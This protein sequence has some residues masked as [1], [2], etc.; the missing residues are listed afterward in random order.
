MVR[1]RQR[2]S[3]ALPVLLL[4]AS[5]LIF[6]GRVI[7]S[8]KPLFGSDFVLYFHP[9]KKFIHDYALTHGT[10]AFW[11]PHQFSG[12]PVI[13]NIQASM[14]YPLG[15]LFYLM[16]T[17]YA[18][19]YTI[20]VHCI[21]GTIFMYVLAR[22]FS[23]TK[24]GAFLAGIV[25][26][27][28]GFFMGHLYAGHLTFVQNYI[29]IP[30]IFFYV[31][32]FLN[33]HHLGYAMMAGLI[34]GIQILG[35]FPQIAFYTILAIILLG[36][37]RISIKLRHKERDAIFR[38]S[39]GMFIIPLLGFSLAAVQLLPTYEFTQ[40]SARSGGV[41]YEFATS[42]SFDPVNFITFLMPNFFG[43]PANG[44]YW[45][46]TQLWQFAELCG[47]VGIAPLLL[48]CF[49]KQGSKARHVRFFFGMLLVLS[50]FLS[51]GRY[52]P[53]YRFIYHLPGFHHFRIPAQ[54][55]YLCVFSVSILAAMGLN[56][57]GRFESYS[58]SYKILLGLGSLVFAVLITAL[59]LL[60]SDLF[61]Y[62]LRVIRP[63]GLTPDLMSQLHKTVRV[64][65]FTGAGVFFLLT[66]L[67]HLRRKH[68]LAASTFITMLVVIATIDLWCFSHSLIRTTELSPHRGKMQLTS[69][70][71]RDPEIHRVVV[72]SDRFWPNDG[73]LY[74]YEDIQGY[75]P[76]ILKRYLAYLNRSQNMPVR[77]EAVNIEFVTQLDNQLIEMLNVK[78]AISS[79]TRILK[80]RNHMPRAFFVR[81]AVT[82]PSEEV[83]DFMMSDDFDPEEVVVLEDNHK[84][85]DLADLFSGTQGHA[86]KDKAEHSTREDSSESCQ[87]T[88][89]GSD[90]IN[91][92]VDVNEDGYLVLSEISYPGWTAYVNGK[93]TE[94][95][96]G[97]YIFRVLPL[98]K[99]RH[100]VVMRFE[101]TSFK[102]GLMITASALVFFV[103]GLSSLYIRNKTKW[104]V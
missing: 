89:Y 79:D 56:G 40:L 16:P 81:K 96:T 104:P 4:V 2:L 72:M 21:L 94:L 17:E 84:T 60:P 18:Y 43:N 42:D 12:T 38:L 76:L 74:K 54:I 50:L 65:I 46:S 98:P 1:Y 90:K 51:L 92:S 3:E 57:I 28:N 11:N 10:I 36:A 69:S 73:L 83:L 27:Y 61:S 14:F 48:L 45:K 5:V 101:P 55:L 19:G 102:I 78:Y 15:F 34:L 7:Y 66:A 35:G 62:L 37:Y 86:V 59:L 99:G 87:I 75:D 44:S 85:T 32:K 6:F 52:N 33:S 29:W 13:A 95:L 8:G 49:L 30:L 88:E 20:I 9:L 91:L 80:L 64:S 26:I 93:K 31:Q 100:D 77:S 103:G 39:C 97:N 70:L 53:L 82:M 22:S 58:S 47:Y 71:K 68:R 24:A 41:S 25:F 23:I 63:S 67:I